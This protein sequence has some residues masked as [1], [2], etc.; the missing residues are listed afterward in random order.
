LIPWPLRCERIQTDLE[1]LGYKGFVHETLVSQRVVFA[2]PS[3]RIH[4]VCH[5]S[6]NCH[7]QTVATRAPNRWMMSRGQRASRIKTCIA[8]RKRLSPG[9]LVAAHR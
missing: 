5:E 8:I 7:G 4:D 6:T 2:T 9:A 3:P 1:P